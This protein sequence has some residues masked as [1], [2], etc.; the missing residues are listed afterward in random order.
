M[1]AGSDK[2]R[3]SEGMKE[4]KPRGGL[5]NALPGQKPSGGAA[6]DIGRCERSE[7]LARQPAKQRRQ[8]ISIGPAIAAHYNLREAKPSKQSQAEPKPSH[9]PDC[10]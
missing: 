3:A 9:A 8:R 2:R 7:M 6:G 10:R 5:L 1:V 4:Q